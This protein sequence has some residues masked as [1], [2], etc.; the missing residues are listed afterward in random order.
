MSK[1][2]KKR[3]KKEVDSS[4]HST[5][6]PGKSQQEGSDTMMNN[7]KAFNLRSCLA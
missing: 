7:V 4:D 5:G 1:S 6:Q 2:K 3:K